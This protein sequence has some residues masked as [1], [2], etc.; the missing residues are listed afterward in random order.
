MYT[1]NYKNSD[2]SDEY[3]P[4]V[5]KAEQ[6]HYISLDYKV[7]TVNIVKQYPKWSSVMD[8]KQILNLDKLTSEEA[9]DLIDS[10]TD[11]QA[12]DS[13]LGGDSDAE[14][15]LPQFSSPSSSTPRTL[16]R[17]FAKIDDCLDFDSD[18]S[19]ADPDFDAITANRTYPNHDI[20]TLD[21]NDSSD[22][23]EPPVYGST[24]STVKQPYQKYQPDDYPWTKSPYLPHLYEATCFQEKSG[25]KIP[26]KDEDLY[27]L[28]EIEPNSTTN[29]IKKAY[30]K[31]ALR[32]HPDKNP[33]N[34]D[35]AKLFHQL[36]KVLEL[37]TDE[38]ARRAYDRVLKG[39]KEAALRHKELDGKRRKLKEDLEE[40]EKNA[41]NSTNFSNSAKLKE[42]IE[43]L[44]KEGS[45]LVQE[46]M[47]YIKTKLKEELEKAEG[48]TNKY[49]LKIK[50]KAGK[51]DKT[52]GGYNSTLLHKFLSKYGDVIALVVSPKKHGSALVEYNSKRAAE[53]AVDLEKGL[54]ANPLE[55]TWMDGA[56][57]RV[58]NSTI[59][60]SDYESV[61]LTKLR[62]AEERKRL[63]A[64]MMAEDEV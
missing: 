6:K 38:S 63:I 62:Q 26:T 48:S 29:D 58:L 37:L 42:E 30:R 22:D 40:R 16:K 10:I 56:S 27:E 8:R 50:W 12:F 53:M 36:T 60:P 20:T 25:P 7:K 34:P 55:I 41:S 64:Q 14:D 21:Y 3:H 57:S 11:D 39:K 59:R 4:D 45:R 52:N 18:D 32:C 5:N 13:D 44:R 2:K 61:V 9:Y 19:V 35:A 43:R 31:K 49:R 54:A 28:L 47:E 23:D 51:N 33:D 1:D 17:R 24:K 46:E 15:D